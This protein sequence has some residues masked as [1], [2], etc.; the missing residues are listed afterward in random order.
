MNSDS[1]YSGSSSDSAEPRSP[2]AGA[3]CFNRMDEGNEW[4]QQDAERR[5]RGHSALEEAF[6]LDIHDCSVSEMHR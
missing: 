2:F 4:E 5:A 1:R 3:Q 6:E